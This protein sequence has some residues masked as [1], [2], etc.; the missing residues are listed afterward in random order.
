MFASLIKQGMT[1]KANSKLAARANP[2]WREFTDARL[3]WWYAVNPRSFYQAGAEIF[4]FIILLIRQ[5]NSWYRVMGE[6]PRLGGFSGSLFLLALLPCD[7]APT[8]FSRAFGDYPQGPLDQMASRY[9][10]MSVMVSGVS[11]LNILL[12][13]LPNPCEQAGQERFGIH[14]S[15]IV[16]L[17][18]CFCDGWN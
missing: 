5:S 9:I 6:M 2:S 4:F 16:A 17:R 14:R 11:R 10:I 12:L 15:V 1:D 8:V 18:H 7:V 3:P 13:K